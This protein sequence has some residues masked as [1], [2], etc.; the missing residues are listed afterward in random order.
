MLPTHIHV[1]SSTVSAVPA[2]CPYGIGQGYCGSPT[3]GDSTDCTPFKNMTC[4][5]IEGSEGCD[6]STD[7]G[8]VMVTQ[9][10][11]FKFPLNPDPTSSSKPKHMYDDT[12]LTVGNTYQVIGGHLNGV[13]IKGPAEA[14]GYNVD[15]S[16]IPLPCGGHVTPPVGPGP[17]YHYHKAADC[18]NISTSG[19]HP[20]II[21]YASDG[22]QI[23]GFGDFN[24]MPVLDEC[25]GHF[26]AVDEDG[27]IV[28][29]Y[30]TSPEYNL[31]GVAHKPYYLGCQG[32]SKG[33]CS[34][35]VNEDYDAGSNWCA[36]GCGFEVCVQ[37]G[38][39]RSQLLEYLDTFEGTSAWL[40]NFTVN[41]F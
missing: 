14:N 7:A 34:T 8:D 31:D 17:I 5:C 23:F 10:Q 36:Q 6:T 12:A 35:T 13:Q 30:H 1:Q 37:P 38:T 21:G 41:D 24:G 27:T 16:L 19:S 40:D 15:T 4:P 28:Y 22:F 20:P 11:L 2:Y 3:E 25:H 39:D 18:Q 29:H 33:L 9:Y 26:G 32:P